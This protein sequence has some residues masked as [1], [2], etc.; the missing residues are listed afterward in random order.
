[1][2]TL[3]ERIARKAFR[4]FYRPY[5]RLLWRRGFPGAGRLERLVRRFEES[6]RR[7]DVPLDR[8]AWDAQYAAGRWDFLTGDEQLER[9]R[10]VA[11]LV[12]RYAP[13]A[14]VLDVG[15][16]E[17]V[18]RE[19]LGPGFRY[20]G[21]DLSRE[22]IARAEAR[23]RTAAG[24]A[25]EFEIADA[26]SWR[27]DRRFGAVVLN[28]CLYYFRRPLVAAHRYLGCVEPGGVL[29]VSMFRA[30]RADAIARRLAAALPAA[31]ELELAGPRGR[32]RITLHRHPEGP[33]RT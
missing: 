19:I 32:R 6:S 1:V 12:H 22:A 5:Y 29:V 15:C 21:I 2:P 10:A 23:A 31:E 14:A 9:F 11:G 17:G 25:A 3:L 20:L 24:D 27:T 30:P 7:A 26:E 33:V 8:E 16:G 13:G 28:E 4:P 18:L